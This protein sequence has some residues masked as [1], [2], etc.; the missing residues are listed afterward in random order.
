MIT[1]KQRR[2]EGRGTRDKIN[3]S[4]VQPIN[5]LSPTRPFLLISLLPVNASMD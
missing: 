4:N 2:R 5:L 1:R 3:P